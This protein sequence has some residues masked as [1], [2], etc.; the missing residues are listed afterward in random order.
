MQTN[1]NKNLEQSNILEKT[2][3]DNNNKNNNLLKKKYKKLTLNA[4]SSLDSINSSSTNL[5]QANKC[6]FYLFIFFY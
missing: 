2:K 1:D 5:K 3:K 4:Q 6:K